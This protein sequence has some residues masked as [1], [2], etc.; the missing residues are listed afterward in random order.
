MVKMK[1]NQN[2]GSIEL[3]LNE[4]FYPKAKVEQAIKD[5]QGV[6]DFKVDCEKIILFPK[7]KEDINRLGYEFR[8][9]ILGLI[10][11]EGEL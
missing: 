1:I 5:F 11:N 2:E 8:N 4:N 10:V 3:D 7:D 6:C 9:Y